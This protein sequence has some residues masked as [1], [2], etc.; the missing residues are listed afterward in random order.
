MTHAR[1]LHGVEVGVPEFPK[2]QGDVRESHLRPLHH[3]LVDVLECL[4]A[5]GQ[6][7]KSMHVHVYLLSGF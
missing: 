3:A 2:G 4:A 5:L 6:T 1:D 7:S